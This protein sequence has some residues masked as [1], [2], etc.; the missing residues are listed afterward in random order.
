MFSEQNRVALILMCARVYSRRGVPLDDLGKVMGVD[1]RQL[2]A[3]F[4]EVLPGAH[5]ELD[6]GVNKALGR[7]LAYEEE[8]G[9]HK[10]GLPKWNV[11]SD[12]YLEYLFTQYNT[13]WVS[14][15]FNVS[16]DAARS[17]KYRLKEKLKKQG[18]C[19]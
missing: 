13:K 6:D 9:R 17:K 2:W 5:P 8:I 7:W 10:D 11:V 15:M 16:Y 14:L 3:Y 4:Q 12:T 18:I 19:L 1:G